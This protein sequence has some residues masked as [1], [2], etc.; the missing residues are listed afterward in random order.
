MSYSLLFL[1]Q[2]KKE[3]DRL[4]HSIKNQFKKKLIERLETP[5]IEKDRLH[6]QLKHCY[7]I[8]LRQAGYRLVYQVDKHAITILI[9]AIGRRDHDAI[10]LSAKARF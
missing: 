9:I 6:G 5:E 2:A 3:W 4:D 1:P 10:Y 7:K 8:K